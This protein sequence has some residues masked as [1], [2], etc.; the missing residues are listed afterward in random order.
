LNVQSQQGSPYGTQQGYGYP[1]E[2]Y[3]NT[4]MN[5]MQS[6][7]DV[8]P[9][10]MSA[11]TAHAPASGAPA[12]LSHYA[13]PSQPSIIQPGPQ[14]PT[15]N[16]GYP[17]YGYANGVPSQPASSSMSNALVPQAIQLP[18]EFL[19][20]VTHVTKSLTSLSSNVVWRTE[21]IPPRR[22]ELP[23]ASIRPHRTNRTTRDETAGHCDAL[24]R[25]RQSLL[26]SRGEGRV[27]RAT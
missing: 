21:S 11:A 12:S 22:S 9:S 6:Y 14:Y 27:R 23:A 24:G 7:A 18:G 8:H 13:Y 17:S 26:S 25:R 19:S 1:Q 16:Q 15:A 10:H 2:G 5:Q 4:S 3:N 20:T